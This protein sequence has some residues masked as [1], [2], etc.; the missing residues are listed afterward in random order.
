MKAFNQSV[1]FYKFT[2]KMV[3]KNIIKFFFKTYLSLDLIFK[4]HMTNSFT[5]VR[6]SGFILLPAIGVRDL[7][8]SFYLIAIN[9]IISG[10][11]S[12]RNLTL[13]LIYFW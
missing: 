11:V 8:W 12:R 3:L 7:G 1:S 9:I 4:Q 5:K 10:N 2:K 6:T 13:I